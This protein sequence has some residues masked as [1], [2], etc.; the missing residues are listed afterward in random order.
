MLSS[1]QPRLRVQER[2]FSTEEFILSFFSTTTYFL[3]KGRKKQSCGFSLLKAALKLYLIFRQSLQCKKK[4][5]NLTFRM[6]KKSFASLK[7]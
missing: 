2:L 5:L 7:K 1:S 6:L 4:N 3:P